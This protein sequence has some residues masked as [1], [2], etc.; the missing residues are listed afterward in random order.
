MFEINLK[1]LHAQHNSFTQHAP[2]LH[3]SASSFLSRA[4]HSIA[5]PLG[6]SRRLLSASSSSLQH[7]SHARVHDAAQVIT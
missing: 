1:N 7:R 4:N 3:A 5:A 2:T 6:C